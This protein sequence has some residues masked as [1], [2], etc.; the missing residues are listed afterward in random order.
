MSEDH[1][2]LTV[3]HR[4]DRTGIHEFGPTPSREMITLHASGNHT[5]GG[6]DFMVSRVEP[7]PGV[8]PLH[9]HRNHDEALYVIEGELEIQVGEESSRLREGSFAHL[10]QGVPHTWRPLG[11]DTS[12]F[13]CL[14][15]PGGHVGVLE[16]LAALQ[17]TQQTPSPEEFEPILAAYDIEMVGPPLDG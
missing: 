14:F 9:V 10:P 4:T 11:S 3:G 1:S 15:A 17:A 7:G 12:R 8:I 2:S 13:I 6:Y 5:D 16:D